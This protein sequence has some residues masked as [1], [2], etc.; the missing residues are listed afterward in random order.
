MGFILDDHDKG[1]HAE[2]RRESF[3]IFDDFGRGFSVELDNEQIDELKYLVD[4]VYNRIKQ[5]AVKSGTG[6]HISQQP[7]G[8]SPSG[9]S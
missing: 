9:N 2:C 6:E 1:I 7:H 8:A 4:A 5:T 3:V